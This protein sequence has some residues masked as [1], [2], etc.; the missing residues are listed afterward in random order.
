[1]K[2]QTHLW[3]Q[4]YD[5]PVNDVLN[6]EDDVAKALAHEMRVHLTS[7][8]QAELSQSHPV[9]PEA[10]N[11]YLQGHYF[12][13]RNT[14]RDTD[15]A[16]K[17]YERATQLDPSFA[18]AWAGL[19]R[20][21]K[22]QGATRLIPEEEGNRLAREAVE[23]ALAL[24]PN[25][26]EAH[27]QMG[28][29]KQQ[30]DFDWVG[31]DASRQR[32]VELEPGNVDA[33]IAAAYSAAQLD[34]F[35]EA[36]RL[37]RRAVGL[38]PLNPGSWQA[39]GEIEFFVGQL[40][41][42]AA[43]VKKALELSPDVFPG[44]ILLSK[45]YVMLGRPNDALPQIE[46]IRYEHERAYLRAIAYYALGREKE[47]DALLREFIAKYPGNTYQ[48]ADVYAFRN[49]YD[50]AFRWLDQAYAQRN[51]G[52]TE[53]KVDPLLKS[54]HNDPRFAALLKKLNLPN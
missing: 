16:A 53:T 46:L 39:R 23:R 20:V 37:T 2:D 45:I 14:D 33:V 32:A 26:A 41:Q 18:L 8:Q 1:V 3:S 19:S 9:N 21:R 52:L 30:V 54:L 6:I 42:A 31:A 17:Y 40:D 15:M 51:S 22:W 47:S 43:D 36:L 10:F 29:I 35:D 12:F 5:Y 34:R 4:D 50:E 24:N 25:L 44:P 7:Q 13:E 49:Q 27:I 11:A 38:D 28:R 48:I